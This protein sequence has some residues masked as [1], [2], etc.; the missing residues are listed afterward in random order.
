MGFIYIDL[1]N[2]GTKRNTPFLGDY[3]RDTNYAKNYNVNRNFN[4]AT[5]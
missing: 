1:L 4:T 3:T 5:I 2:L